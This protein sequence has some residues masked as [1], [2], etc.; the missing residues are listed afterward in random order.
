MI[1]AYADDGLRHAAARGDASAVR[2]LLQNGSDPG[3]LDNA[4]LRRA[5][6]HGHTQ[7]VRLL[8]KAGAEFA[9]NTHE[10]LKLAAENEDG[11]NLKI[12]LRAAKTAVPQQIL[13]QTLFAATIAANAPGVSL[14]IAAGADPRAQGSLPALLAASAGSVGVLKILHGHGVSFD[15]PDG[16]VLYNAVASGHLDASKYILK[17]GVNVNAR[18]NLATT[19]AV[20][21]GDSEILEALLDA[22]GTLPH[23]YLVTDAANNDSVETLL[24]LIHQGYEFQS[25][26]ADICL[27][28]VRRDSPRV[29]RYVY[30]NSAVSQ[31]ARD[32]QLQVAVDR[33]GESIFDFLIQN[34]AEPSADNS[35][36]LKRAI[37]SQ[38]LL[39]AGKLI[40]A[41]ARICDL[42]ASAF[43]AT[44]QA[45]NWTFLI[46][47]LQRAMPVTGLILSTDQAAVFFR[48]VSPSAFIC[49]ANGDLLAANI[50]RERNQFA[51]V[52]GGAA[53]QKSADEAAFLTRW[54]TDFMV[55]QQGLS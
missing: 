26:A 37:K 10:F 46:D 8:I 27:A 2:K 30:S 48:Q 51:K 32:L 49:D 47:L 31:R 39:F 35:D 34:G 40:N 18:D 52:N 55:M 15:H 21:A 7:I 25:Y 50:R 38:K 44:T 42:D 22:G 20:A 6:R 5:L 3:D 41:G 33:A 19:K 9:K 4:A 45:G 13:N 29:L 11:R 23:P 1:K 16:Q 54:L 17:T 36:A 53:S 43:V 12:L 24:V 28:A 14:L